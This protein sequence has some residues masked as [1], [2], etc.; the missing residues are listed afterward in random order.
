MMNNFLRFNARVGVLFKFQARVQ[1]VLAWDRPTETWSLLA[2]YTLICLKPYLLLALPFAIIIF[3]ILVPSF[4]ARHPAPLSDTD[5]LRSVGFSPRG[6]PLAPAP[7]VALT[8]ETSKDFLQNLGGLQNMMD[9]LSNVHDAVVDHV[10]P[11]IN[12]SDEPLSSAIFVWSVAGLLFVLVFGDKVPIRFIALIA[13]WA[14][15]LSLNP[16]VRRWAGR[17]SHQFLGQKA[18]NGDNTN[19]G[20]STGL[21]PIQVPSPAELVERVKSDIKLDSPPETREVEVFEL[22]RK[23]PVTGEWEAWLFTPT[24]YDPL[25]AAR[26]AGERPK[27]ER[28]FEDVLPPEGWEWADKKWVLDLWSREWVEERIITSVEVETEGER[29]VYDLIP[30]DQPNNNGEEDLAEEGGLAN[31]SARGPE[32][33][34]VPGGFQTSWEEAEDDE[35]AGRRGNWRRRRWVRTVRRKAEDM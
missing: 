13:G 10:L 20:K 29:W 30:P 33:R 5:R 3:G 22:Q 15:I 23:D 1:R 2:V 28:F 8:K 18:Q 12:F 6:P 14:G 35:G 17:L 7:T 19:E 26:L 9:D 16:W 25:S 32:Q 27:G 4:I 21:I 34:R 31:G 24:P 11:V